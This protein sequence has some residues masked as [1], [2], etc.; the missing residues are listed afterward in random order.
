MEPLT[1]DGSTLEGG[2]QLV[3]IVL[4]LSALTRQTVIINKIRANRRNPVTGTGGGL[5]QQHVVAARWLANIC[6]AHTEGLEVGSSEL[7]FKPDVKPPVADAKH[8]RD[9][10]QLPNTNR[11]AAYVKISVESLG[12]IAL[13]LQAIL[14]YILLSGRFAP[15]PV[16]L[17]IDGGTHVTTAPSLSYIHNVLMPNLN[18]MFSCGMLLI[19]RADSYT[20]SLGWVQGGRQLGFAH[21]TINPFK[22][23]ERLQCFSLQPRGAISRVIISAYAPKLYLHVLE[24]EAVDQVEEHLAPLGVGQD[25][26]IHKEESGQRQ[27]YYVQFVV[28]VEGG[29]RLA[30]DALWHG[31]NGRR[32]IVPED[33]AEEICGRAMQ[34]LLREIRTDYPVDHYMMDQLPVFMG[35]A[36]GTSRMP[37]FPESEPAPAESTPSS[38]PHNLPAQAFAPSLTARPSSASAGIARG[39]SWATVA[40]SPRPVPPPS[41]STAL[42]APELDSIQKREP[43]MHVKTARWAVSN[44]IGAFFEPD[45][46]CEGVGF[47]AGTTNWNPV[48]REVN[49]VDRPV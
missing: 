1:I 30:A 12:S 5:K 44:M 11:L 28:E 41:P 39:R 42:D 15:H 29:L 32:A 33:V 16:L 10:V 38:T 35:L 18:R 49:D 23:A 47:E 2:G 8:N 36:E 4:G 21:F 7:F 48:E 14:P 3:R 46:T 43:T 37:D 45:G 27:R 17:R 31:G 25:I 24:C 6:C 34:Y 22:S 40:S 20:D 13:V 9:L 26:S 19:E